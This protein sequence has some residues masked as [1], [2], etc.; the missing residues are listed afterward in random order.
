LSWIVVITRSV[1]PD[2]ME[3]TMDDLSLLAPDR[4]ALI[5]QVPQTRLARWRSK[6][7]GPDYVKIEGRILYSRDAVVDFINRS[8]VRTCRELNRSTPAEAVETA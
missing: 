1:L 5:L 8:T 6:G 3:M 2:C 7:A 4:A